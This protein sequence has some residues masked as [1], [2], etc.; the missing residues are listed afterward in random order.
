MAVIPGAGRERPLV[1]PCP[2][3]NCRV[4]D[5]PL[6]IPDSNRGRLPSHRRNCHTCSVLIGTG[7]LKYQRSSYLW[8]SA[9]R[10]LAEVL[11]RNHL[12]L[13]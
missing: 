6:S 11:E 1:R 10:T 3:G 5:V 9:N 4:L 8:R 7:V 12:C 13:L 2:G